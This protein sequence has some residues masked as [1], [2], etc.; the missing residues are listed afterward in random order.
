MI[1]A[2]LACAPEERTAEACGSCHAEQYD[3]WRGSAHARSGTTPAF[4]ASLP[5]VRRAWGPTAEARCVACHQPGYGGDE[6]I[7]CAACHLAVGNRTE[8]D[9]ALVVDESAPIGVPGPVSAPH[10]TSV[11]PFL[12]S[13]ALCATCHEVTG[14][15]LLVERT[16]TEYAESGSTQ[17]C[18]DCHLPDGDHAIPGF[19]GE[20]PD[21][22]LL[23]RVLDL[24]IVGDRV[25][26]ENVGAAHRV[27][28]GAAFLRD[29]VVTATV[30]G[31]T[32]ELRLSP[33][34]VEDGVPVAL[35][36]MAD[37]IEGEGLA[38][39]EIR[40][41]PLG[42]GVAVDAALVFRPF[43]EDAAEAL[44]L[45]APEEVIVATASRR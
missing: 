15:Q 12:K 2:L 41:L 10:A 30:D 20:D 11:R 17:T 34:P 18:A 38:P 23:A 8:A 39:G 31:E 7:G 33:I 13:P 29:L 27:P 26:V 42:D 28:T 1:V 24:R 19:E 4:L 44:G 36:T 5:E 40:T 35:P 14:P 25:E 3:A 16:G 9:G 6:G 45:D 43:R 37:A 21:V 22:A 32:R